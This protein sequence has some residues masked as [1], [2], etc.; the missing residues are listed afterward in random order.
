MPRSN[1]FTAPAI[2]LFAGAAWYALGSWL[3]PPVISSIY[4]G[5]LLVRLVSQI[6]GFRDQPLD[7]YLGQWSGIIL[8][9]TAAFL[10]LSGFLH[11]LNSD[12][13]WPS[14]VGKATPGTIGAIRM[15]VCSILLLNVFWEDLSSTAAL[16]RGMLEPMGLIQL[17]YLLPGFEWFLTSAAS[18]AIFQWVTAA[19]LIFGFAGWK[20]SWTIPIG[21]V[22]YLLFAG[23]LRHYAWFYHT[24]L[25]PLFL[26]IL[27]SFLP[28]GDG[29]SVDRLIRI[30][31][32]KPVPAADKSSYMYGWARYAIWAT[33]ALPYVAAGFSKIRNGGLF[34]WDAV[35]FKYILFYSTLR[36]M[37]FDFEVS[38]LLRNAPDFLF[39]IMALAA[40]GGEVLYGLVLFSR[41]ARWIL[42]TLMG[43]MQIGILFLQNILFLDLI[44]LQVIF[45]NFIPLRSFLGRRLSLAKGRIR[46][47]YDTQVPTQRRAA[48]IIESLDLF[49]RFELQNKTGAKLSAQWK[50]DTYENARLV[51]MVIAVSP[52]VWILR[53][54]MILP[55][56]SDWVSA[57]L[58]DAPKQDVTEKTPEH[59]EKGYRRVVVTLTSILLFCWV[60]RLEFYPFT[61]MQMFSKV[62]GP[63][64]TYELPLAHLR[65][66]DVVHLPIEQTVPAMRDSRYRRLLQSAMNDEE[67]TVSAEL[68]EIVA[69]RWNAA[70]VA[71]DQ[72][73]H[74]EIERWTWNYEEDPDN[75]AHGELVAT[76]AYPVANA[77]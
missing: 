65:S 30:W 27:L 56:V 17:F 48:Q 22:C 37:E 38:L 16:P 74:M 20:T 32:G 15:L 2:L 25:I 4:H 7:F 21:A 47:N 60:F 42:P 64:V 55:G 76:R 23:L 10:G 41:R 46:L 3:I 9:G 70:A 45:F 73:T 12:R 34:W 14:L 11:L 19:V 63:V 50:D 57:K 54:I 31:R 61:S 24:G 28:S 52:C 1:R 68:F 75:P 49:E 18:L 77:N 53:P 26:L 36:P 62:R 43:L 39:E 72:I 67:E 29:W 69:M 8:A 44:I 58:T 33:M 59:S 35:N 51:R 6:P 66:G 40:L 13:R 5:D 71:A